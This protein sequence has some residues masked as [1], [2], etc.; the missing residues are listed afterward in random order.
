MLSGIKF[1]KCVSVCARTYVIVHATTSV[2][3]PKN[4]GLVDLEWKMDVE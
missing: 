3:D 4:D 2:E 1:V